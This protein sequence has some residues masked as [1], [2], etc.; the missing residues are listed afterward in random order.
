MSI[1]GVDVTM[2]VAADLEIVHAA[3]V[4]LPLHALIVIDLPLDRV[5]CSS[6]LRGKTNGDNLCR[7]CCRR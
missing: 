3:C 4:Y 7:F 1:I 6:Y 2:C 5:S